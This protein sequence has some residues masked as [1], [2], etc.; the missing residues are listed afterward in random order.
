MVSIWA[1]TSSVAHAVSLA[2]SLTSLATTAKPLPASPA[3]AASIVALSASRLVCWAMVRMTL[4]TLPIAAELALSARMAACAASA[5]SRALRTV[6]AL[7]WAL[8]A[9]SRTVALVGS[10]ALATEA[11]LAR[12]R[13]ASPR[14]HEA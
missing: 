4:V 12:M 7:S 9:I 1:A 13:S 14:T 6:R 2:R 5:S 3:R 10:E 8:E 11:T